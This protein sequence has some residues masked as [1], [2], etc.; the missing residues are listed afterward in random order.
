[1][2]NAP[3]AFADTMKIGR[4]FSLSKLLG[5]DC[6]VETVRKYLILK[7]IS[8]TVGT[9]DSVTTLTLPASIANGKN[10]TV[11]YRVGEVRAS[12]GDTLWGNSAVAVLTLDTA[13]TATGLSEEQNDVPKIF[14]LHQNYPNPFNPATTIS[15]TLEKDGYTTL[16]M[17]DVLGREVATLVAGALKAGVVNKVTF[18][19][20]KLSSGVY[21]SRLES[22]GNVQMKKLM[23]L[24]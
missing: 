9:T 11:K 16:K 20:S 14:A 19:G 13:T 1:V 18:N 12:V 22:S 24:K 5:N 23:L 4:T 7:V 15:F 17:Y 10:D 8:A 2:D 21:F 6:D 3:F